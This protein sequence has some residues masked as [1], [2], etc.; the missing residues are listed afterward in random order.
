[1]RRVERDVRA[2]EECDVIRARE[3]VVWF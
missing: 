1:M 2:K 3:R